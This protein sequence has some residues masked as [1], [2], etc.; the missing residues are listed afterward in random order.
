MKRYIVI[1]V[2]AI[3]FCPSVQASIVYVD[4]D[5]SSGWNDIVDLVW[6]DPRVP[7]AAPLESTSS[8][9]REPFGGNAGAY[10]EST[11]NWIHGDA[12]VSGGMNQEN[13]YS[14]SSGA[15]DTIDFSFD[16]YA[17]ID[18]PV[19]SSGVPVE[20]TSMPNLGLRPFI[21][22]DGTRYFSVVQAATISSSWGNFSLMSLNVSDF[23]AS[24]VNPDFS[25]NGGSITFGYILGHGSTPETEGTPPI[26]A[27]HGLDNWSVTINPVPVPGAVWLLGTGLLGIV[28][29]RRKMKK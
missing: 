11:I 1:I 26:T 9:S 27:V 14:L 16:I 3:L 4:G 29:L 6:D 23:L 20:L 2:A 21:V 13:V 24:G 8:V 25:I 15:I 12:I 22:Q 28:G 5:F 19:D 18:D 10:R 17:N 7:D